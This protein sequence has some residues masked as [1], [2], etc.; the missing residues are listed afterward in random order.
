MARRMRD[1][2]AVAQKRRVKLLAQYESLPPG[3]T[4]TEFAEKHSV[5]RARMSKQLIKAREERAKSQ[6]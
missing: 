4:V 5:T 6:V 1:I 2:K 3:T